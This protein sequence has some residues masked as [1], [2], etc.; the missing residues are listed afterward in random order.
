MRRRKLLF[1]GLFLFAALGWLGVSS[2]RAPAQQSAQQ[3]VSTA[4]GV[5]KSQA[6]LV[7]VDVVVADHKG[8]YI[9]DLEAKDF[10]VYED[11]KEQTISSFSRGQEPSWPSGPAQRRYLV[12]FFDNSTMDLPDQ[13][14]ARQA[15]AQFID[16]TA[17][18]DRLMAIADFGGTL[19]IAQNF[20]ANADRLKQVVSGVKFS[21]VNPNDNAAAAQVAALGGI[22]DLGA[23]G[24][25]GARNMLLAVRDLAKRLL[26]VPGRKTVILFSSGFPL[27]PEHQSELTATVD[28]CNRA[29]VAI[30]PLDVRGL[31]TT[32]PGGITGPQQQIGPPI[33]RQQ[34]PNATVNAPVFP[35]YTGL[36]AFLLAPAMSP[37][38]HGGGGGTGGGGGGGGGGGRG[39]GGGSVGGGGTGGGGGGRGGGSTGGGST[40]GGGTGGGRGGTGGGNTGG[41]GT[42]GGR[43]GSTGSGGGGGARGGGG[44][45]GGLGNANRFGN[46]PL[47]QPRQIIPEIPVSATTNQQVLYA[48]AAGT[49]GFPI[50]NSNDFLAGLDKIAKELNEYY[51]LGYVPPEKTP[52]GTCHTIKVRVERKGVDVRSRTGYCD[53]RSAD[54]LAGKVEGKAL[55]TVAASPQAGTVQVSVRA[56]YFYEGANVARVNLVLEIPGDALDFEKE[57]GEFHS[58]VNVLGIATREDGSVGARFSDTVKVD[59]DKKEMKQFTKGAF[60]Y[61]NTFEIA[62]GKYNLKLVLSPGGQ[63]FAKYEAPLVIDPYDGKQFGLSAVALSDKITPVSQLST[64]LDAAL[65]EEKTPLVVR[66]RSNGQSTDFQLNPS[67]TNRFGR[68]ERVALYV[69]VYEPTMLGKGNETRVGVTY[70]VVDRKT[71]QQVYRSPTI[72]VNDFAQ[73]GNPVIPIGMTLPLDKLQAGDYRLEVTARDSAGNASPMRATDFVLN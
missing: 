23:V 30:Y 5:I 10:L 60:S 41:G 55:E 27:T 15:A 51:I 64:S 47:N 13:A 28:A 33:P 37:P 70:S 20:T 71:N 14:R 6:N 11:G 63:N 22:P 45:G 68:D 8:N 48:L 29:N 58:D 50:F 44:G 56:P 2:L 19:Q 26:T 31:M 42:G 1:M 7:L 57:K 46:N 54:L 52:E 40:G 69:E 9:R 59:V 4:P 24:D 18:A 39:G 61:Q 16:K 35:H 32:E 3:P 25:F 62:P 72:L 38:Q 17:S 36:Y 49:G 34:G 21:A 65:L 67:P 12:L 53:V 73:P 66:G 43:G